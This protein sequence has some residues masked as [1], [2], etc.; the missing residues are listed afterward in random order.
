MYRFLTKN[1]T[2][3]AFGIGLLAILLFLIPALAGIGEFND[4]S[5]DDQY[6]T[7]IFDIGLSVTLFLIAACFVVALLFGVYQVATNPKGAIK[8]IIGLVVMVAAFFI[9]Y[10]MSQPETSESMVATL[11]KFSISEGISKYVSGAIYTVLA[12]L[13]IASIAVVLSE[14][15]NAFK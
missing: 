14:I 4:L 9:F 12:L 15:R 11:S 1:G 2:S 7:S 8:M 6:Q 5:R 10:T 3:V 13:G